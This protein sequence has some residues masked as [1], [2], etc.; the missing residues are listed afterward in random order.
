MRFTSFRQE[1]IDGLAIM[2][3]FGAA[4]GLTTSDPDYPGRLETLIQCGTASLRAAAEVL[5]RG[6]AIDLD[7]VEVLPVL[8]SPGKII[9]VGLNYADHS[10]ESGF[11]QP[12]YPT[13]FSRFN[14]SLIGHGAPL[15]RP[16]QS[17]QLDYEGE[18]A[19]VIGTGGKNISRACALDHVLGYSIFNDA[20]V[21]DYQFKTPQWIVGKNFDNTGAFGPALVTAD[22][23][24]PGCRGLKLVTRLNGETVQCAMIEDMIFDVATQIA[25]V[26]EVITLNPGDVFV[27]GTPAGVG[28][29]RK[30]P[31]WMKAG[32][33]C[34]VEIDRIGY[35]EIRSLMKTCRPLADDTRLPKTLKIRKKGNDSDQR[36]YWRDPTPRRTRHSFT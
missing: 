31:L 5:S 10:A 12:D 29:S 21:R 3:A 13:L 4:T 7:G 28:L 30:P 25:L 11:K 20:S 24:P 26:S 14:S 23:L 22:E 17:G 33:L 19:A 9:C 35:C 18:L 15:V 27:T 8:S 2:S 32:D 1:G 16:R 6:R 36:L 34:E